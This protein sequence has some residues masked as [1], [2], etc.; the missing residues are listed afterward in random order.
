MGK[1]KEDQ[2]AELVTE[3][4]ELVSTL[5]GLQKDLKPMIRAARDL[6]HQEA[7]TL[8]QNAVGARLAA[9][10][11]D[12]GKIQK[13]NYAYLQDVHDRDMERI[14][15]E[16]NAQFAQL[17]NAAFGENRDPDEYVR[18]LAVVK[19]ATHALDQV[20]PDADAE[21]K[22]EHMVKRMLTAGPI[23]TLVKS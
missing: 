17:R 20:V 18:I 12:L 2:L 8:V 7:E 4:R 16:L 10:G 6:L 14:V 1:S 15:A 9:M 3:A 21:A 23:I 11:E 22:A 19:A 13:R 5:R